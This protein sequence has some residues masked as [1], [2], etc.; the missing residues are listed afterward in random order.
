MRKAEYFDFFVS[1]CPYFN[2]NTDVNNG[3]GCTHP[4]Q[5]ENDDGEG[6]CYCWSCPLGYPADEESLGE[7]DIEWVDG[8]PVPDSMEED[9][10][11]ILN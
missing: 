9:S 8:R 11:I 2:G 1:K 10:Y 3:Y 5:K 7:D 6:K 4:E